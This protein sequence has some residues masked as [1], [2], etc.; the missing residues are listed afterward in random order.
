MSSILYIHSEILYYAIEMHV[1]FKDI[2]FN[3]STLF[4]LMFI[5][6]DLIHIV[7]PSFVLWSE[8]VFVN[9]RIDIARK[10]DK[11]VFQNIRYRPVFTTSPSKLSQNKRRNLRKNRANSR[12]IFYRSRR[13]SQN[14]TSMGSIT[15]SMESSK[16]DFNS[17]SPI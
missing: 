3:N 17:F 10:Y 6:I 12:N 9:E 15:D 5:L 13:L 4:I 14:S 8:F 11:S 7:I 16:H 1:N 2:S